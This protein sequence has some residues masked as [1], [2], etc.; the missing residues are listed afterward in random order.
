MDLVVGHENIPLD[1]AFRRHGD[2]GVGALMVGSEPHR[3]LDRQCLHTFD[4]LGGALDGVLLGIAGWMALGRVMAPLIAGSRCLSHHCRNRLE[5]GIALDQGIRRAPSAR[6]DIASGCIADGGVAALGVTH[7]WWLAPWPR[8]SRK[9]CLQSGPPGA[10]D[11]FRASGVFVRRYIWR[12]PGAVENPIV[13]V[14]VSG[15]AQDAGVV[16]AVGEHEVDLG[17]AQQVELVDG[18]PGRDMVAFACRPRTSVPRCPPTKR[19]GRSTR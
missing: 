14:R 11:L 15:L 7:T 19:A 16:A 2:V 9:P 6:H 13:A 10:L 4:A 5:L 8:A 12:I 18:T 1:G 17:I 3:H